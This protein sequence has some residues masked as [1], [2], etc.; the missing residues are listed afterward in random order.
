MHET[1]VQG[2]SGI[3]YGDLMVKWKLHLGILA[4][5]REYMFAR[6]RVDHWWAATCLNSSWLHRKWAHLCEPMLAHAGEVR[7]AGEQKQEQERGREQE[8]AQEQQQELRQ[9]EGCEA[10]GQGRRTGAQAQRWRPTEQHSCRL[11]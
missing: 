8:Q 4:R 5:N 11:S 10:T 1:L 7:R 2:L 3:Y 6:S 9:G